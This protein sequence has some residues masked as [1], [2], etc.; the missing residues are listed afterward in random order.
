MPES[1]DWTLFIVN[2]ARKRSEWD[3]QKAFGGLGLA[4]VGAE[5]SKE[6][7]FT[8]DEMF[9]ARRPAEMTTDQWRSISEKIRLGDLEAARRLVSE[10][11][12]LPSDTAPRELRPRVISPPNPET[13]DWNASVAELLQS[14]VADTSLSHIQRAAKAYIGYIWDVDPRLAYLVARALQVSDQAAIYT[15]RE[16]LPILSEIAA[17]LVADLPAEIR[18]AIP[19]DALDRLKDQ[20]ESGT[21]PWTKDQILTAASALG[22]LVEHCRANEDLDENALLLCHQAIGARARLGPP[23]DA[24]LVSP[25]LENP[26]ITRL[27]PTATEIASARAVH[28]YTYGL[29]QAS[30]DLIPAG[31][32]GENRFVGWTTVEYP[33]LI[34]VTDEY[35][36]FCR[37][38]QN[39]SGA[40][41]TTPGDR[42]G[43]TEIAGGLSL[44]HTAST[45]GRNVRALSHVKQPF[46]WKP[47]TDQYWPAVRK[48]YPISHGITPHAYFALLSVGDGPILDWDEI[49][50]R[51]EAK[52]NEQSTKDEIN[53]KIADKIGDAIGDIEIYGVKAKGLVAPLTSAFTSAV[54][55][56]LEWLIGLILP[57]NGRFRKVIVTHL[58]VWPEKRLVPTSFV[59]WATTGAGK[60]A[61]PENP[62]IKVP[63]A[64]NLKDRI[65]DLASDQ[66]AVAATAQQLGLPNFAV[67]AV[68]WN[69]E[70]RIPT[71]GDTTD[72]AKQFNLFQLRNVTRS[73]MLW[74]VGGSFGG[75]I[76]IPIESD[77]GALYAVALRTEVRLAKL[78]GRV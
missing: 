7:V 72:P 63:E 1:S 35:I 71:S 5:I 67:P 2:S 19:N 73:S 28:T 52:L 66:Q 70:N 34:R 23:P 36:L 53:K 15:I 74:P 22:G 18:T 61:N 78:R 32:D 41:S 6:T 37:E 38:L 47:D 16:S 60:P 77:A 62:Q 49:K 57:T 40:L 69:G 54:L 25:P 51:I 48:T 20:I 4:G 59:T 65:S 75:R 33:P 26:D 10:L 56:L 21:Q 12:L 44:N 31:P 39:R 58:T 43:L 45:A 17:T 55:D 46:G 27:R 9:R 3:P 24:P 64:V 14:P 29:E 30:L 11:P 68:C 42:P 8:A 13:P 76:F 50:K